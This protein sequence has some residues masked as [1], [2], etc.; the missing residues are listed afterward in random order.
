[1]LGL[2][3]GLLAAGCADAPGGDAHLDLVFDVCAPIRLSAPG[4]T[5]AQLAGVD[6]AAALWRDHGVYED[7]VGVVFVNT[8]LTD[9]DARTITIAH[10]LGHAFGLWHVAASE[11]PSIMNPGNLQVLPTVDDQAALA[12]RWGTCAD[13]P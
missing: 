4:A 1:M 9:P 12:A 7:E 11:R 5:A 10:E 2:G 6:A 8:D 13:R 3:A